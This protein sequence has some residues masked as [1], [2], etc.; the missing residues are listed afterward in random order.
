MNT[1]IP[2]NLKYLN[3]YKI[4]RKKNENIDKHKIIIEQGI[5]QIK[6]LGSK[7]KKMY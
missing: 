6:I 5:C 7:N 3:Y 4:T 2:Q 1:K